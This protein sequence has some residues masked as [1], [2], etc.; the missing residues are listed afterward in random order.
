M[1]SSLTAP[2]RLVA[3]RYRLLSQIG[4]GGMGTVWLALD[5][6][7]GRQVAVK[8]LLPPVT[9]D[10]REAQ[11]QKERALREGRIAARLSN[12]HAISVY[13]VAVEGDRPWLVMEYLPSR[14][15]AEVLAEDGLLRVD[16]AAT[17]G[18]QVADALAAT[19]AAG[20]VHRDVKPAN[21]LIGRGERVEGIVKITDFGISHASGDVTLTQTGQITGTPAFLAP[22]VAQGEE[23]QS[24]SDVFSL[25]ATLY[26]CLEGEPPFGMGDNALQ[27]LH[28]VAGAQIS[29]PQR[30]GMMTRPL[31]RMLAPDPRN[32][33]TMGSVR[34]DLA[35]LAA[36]R[37][38]DPTTILMARTHLRSAPGRPP[39]A[40]FPPIPTP[41]PLPDEPLPDGARD[42]AVRDDAVREDALHQAG[43]PEPAPAPPAPRPAEPPG[44]GR[45]RRRR[46]PVVA[47]VV[48]L[49]ALAVL[50]GVLLTRGDGGGT[51]AQGGPVASSSGSAG[52]PTAGSPT[53]SS[54]SS[55]SSAAPST[56]SGGSSAAPPSSAAGTSGSAAPAAAGTGDP[57]GFVSTYHSLLPGDTQAAYAMTGPGLRSSESYANYQ[58]FW[59]RFRAVRATNVRVESPTSV[60]AELDYTLTDGSAQ[61]ELHR[62]TLVRGADGKLLLNRDAFVQAL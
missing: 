56:T 37:D 36:G 5:E 25:G 40:Q 52:S 58:A 32:R 17:I 41:T 47:A 53:A 14:S 51:S 30:A 33:P 61:R 2:G 20:I 16:Q 54:A 24:P 7:L 46:G 1:T 19:H 29:P 13:D 48:V 50:A 8:Q 43:A 3:G 57:A 21:V 28:R 44:D 59:Q 39:T 35:R 38:G 55:A 11:R 12:P 60:T 42:G 23:P 6:L 15:L 31:L 62:F 26:T 18:A 10:E 27:L 4:G 9:A 45:R 34:D 22:E 49:A